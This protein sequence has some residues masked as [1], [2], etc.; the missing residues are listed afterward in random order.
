[1]LLLLLPHE[2]MSWLQ[3]LFVIDLRYCL[4]MAI[5]WPDWDGLPVCRLQVEPLT[6]T[7][8]LSSVF[9]NFSKNIH[10]KGNKKYQF[11]SFHL[12]SFSTRKQCI[13]AEVSKN[14]NVVIKALFMFLS[15][16]DHNDK[17]LN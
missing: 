12:Q 4:P 10:D 7:T 15:H 6:F 17:N 9:G 8:L 3:S 13:Q 1:M 11:C 14:E 2:K 5:D 16:S